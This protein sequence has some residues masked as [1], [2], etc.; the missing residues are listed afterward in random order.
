MNKRSAVLVASGLV[1]AMVSAAFGI[2]MGFTGPSSAGTEGIRLQAHRKP[3]VKT[4]TDRRTV[5]KTAPGGTSGSSTVVLDA[6]PGA[7]GRRIR[8][9]RR[10]RPSKARDDDSSIRRPSHRITGRGR[11]KRSRRSRPNRTRRAPLPSPAMTDAPARR[12]RWS[13][14]RVRLVAWTSGGLAFLISGSAIAAAPKPD[15]EV[16]AKRPRPTPR[17]TIVKHHVVRTVIYDPPVST[18]SSVT[19]VYGGATGGTT[20]SAGSSGGSTTSGGS[21]SGSSG[22]SG[23]SSGSSGGTTTTTG[24]S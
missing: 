8:R 18:G 14:N 17:K 16:G 23:G 1:L 19:Y 10:I 15:V 21:S 12:P 9:R 11:P 4:V 3:V 24:G 13:K 6:H 5:H 7:A 2:M 20:A 22:S